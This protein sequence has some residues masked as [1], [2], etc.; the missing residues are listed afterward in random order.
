MAVPNCSLAVSLSPVFSRVYARFLW[1][2]ARRGESVAAFSNS[3]IAA[4]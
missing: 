3:E 1:I 2:S 4:S